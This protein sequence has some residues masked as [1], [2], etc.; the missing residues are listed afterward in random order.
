MYDLFCWMLG[1]FCKNDHLNRNTQFPAFKSPYNIFPRPQTNSLLIPQHL[2]SFSPVRKT[3]LFAQRFFPQTWTFFVSLKYFLALLTFSSF[4]NSRNF[5]KSLASFVFPHPPTLCLPDRKRKR[6]EPS[7]PHVA[8]PQKNQKKSFFRLGEKQFFS[9]KSKT[10][11]GNPIYT[12]RK[13]IL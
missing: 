3:R 5:P 9:S 4:S 6:N 2:S 8:S 13:Y 7:S 1:R 11:A 12:D 10:A